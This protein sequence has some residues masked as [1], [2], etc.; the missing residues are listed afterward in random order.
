MNGKERVQ[1]AIAR[2][3]VD[4]VPLGLYAVDYD[5]VERVIG[6]KTYVRNKIEI[7]LALW[8]GRRGEV[9]QSLKEDTVAF[10]RRIDCADVLLPK[11][12]QLLPPKDYEPD[13]PKRIADDKWED[14]EGRI[15][16]T[17]PNANEIYCVHDPTL[18]TQDYTVEY[19]DDLPTDV[20]PPDP[21]VFEVFDHVFAELGQERYVAGT[22]GGITALTLLGG[23]ERGLMMYALQP[24]VIAAA[25]RHSVGIQNQLDQ[26]YIRK[27]VPGVLMEQDMAGSNGPLVSPRTFRELFSLS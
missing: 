15:Y 1:A 26:Y 19:F 20:V 13:P 10:Y 8:D 6:H 17:A 22:T 5:T 25:N 7:Q 18:G 12:A 24:E 11:E 21:S 23:T 27:G 9:A 16:Q 3:P 14:R 2:Q 4:R